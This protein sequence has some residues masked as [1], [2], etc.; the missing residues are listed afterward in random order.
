[1]LTL[2][3]GWDYGYSN[4]EVIVTV[5]DVSDPA[6]PEAIEQ[7]RLEGT[8]VTSRAIDGRVYLVVRNNAPDLR[9]VP[10]ETEIEGETVYVYE[11]EAEFRARMA[12][13]LDDELPGYAVTADGEETTAPMLEMPNVYLAG[14]QVTG[15]L[16]NILSF[17]VTDDDAGPAGTTSVFG[18]KGT[19]YV[20]TESLYIVGNRSNRW[21]GWIV[22]NPDVGAANVFKFAIQG[23]DVPL[24]ASGTVPGSV[25]NQFSMDE[26]E[27]NFRLATLTWYQG[28][29]SSNVYVLAQNGDKLEIAGSVTGLA[30]TERIYS[31]RFMGDKGYVVTFRKVDPLFTLDLSDPTDPR[32]VGKLKIPGYSAYL[33]PVGEDHLIGLGRD[34]DGG[35]FQGVQVSLFDVSDMAD[36]VQE[37]VYIWSDDGR[38]G[39]SEAEND[40]HAFGYFPDH[41]ILALP[42]N[43]RW[44]GGD[45]SGL[46]VF[47]VDLVDGFTYL[48]RITHTDRVRRSLRIGEYLYSVSA[49]QIQ[50]H[51]IDD[52]GDRIASVDI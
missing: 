27:G 1:A 23:D 46:E 33:H 38:L 44:G 25:L 51:Q 3:A 47:E 10:V 22:S 12:E 41:G 35:L 6:D 11:T 28:V 39:T 17:D 43:K 5:L 15:P 29:S 31:V 21:D 32:V 36:P 48:G 19:A 14:E 18:V 34:T 9:P 4:P 8:L 37:D 52:P 16:L 26:H 30:P 24:V 2:R 13:E 49:E 42:F 45:E 20:S 40:H 50:V 7:T